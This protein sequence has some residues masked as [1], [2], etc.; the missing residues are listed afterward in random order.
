MDRPTSANGPHLGK[1]GGQ[2]PGTALTPAGDAAMGVTKASR[3]GTTAAK[4]IAS[5]TMTM[6]VGGG[7]PRLGEWRKLL[8]ASYL[9]V[10]I[11]ESSRG[12][13]QYKLL[14]GGTPVHPV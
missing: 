14:E 5:M 6:M 1:G 12:T 8:C 3:A 2:Y 7:G 9:A 11:P 13:V 4:A 10:R